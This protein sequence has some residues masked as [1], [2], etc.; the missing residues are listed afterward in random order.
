MFLGCQNIDYHAKHCNIDPR[1]KG[2]QEDLTVIGKTSSCSFCKGTDYPK[3]RMEEEE[4]EDD[5]DV[6]DDEEEE[7]EK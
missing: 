3:L 4:E 2:I 5:D 6:D 7:E 1:K